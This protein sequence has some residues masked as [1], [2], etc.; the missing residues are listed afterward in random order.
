MPNC[1]T[2][3]FQP[4]V[5]IFNLKVALTLLFSKTSFSTFIWTYRASFSKLRS[6]RGQNTYS[7]VLLA[8][9]NKER[10]YDGVSWKS[11]SRF[12]QASVVSK[13]C[14]Y[15]VL[16]VAKLS[17]VPQSEPNYSSPMSSSRLT[18]R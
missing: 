11:G 5:C 15:F 18:G 12:L 16:D 7:S 6:S 1:L 9:Q 4:N 13:F 8:I 10:I 17:S 3:Y 2:S 14:S